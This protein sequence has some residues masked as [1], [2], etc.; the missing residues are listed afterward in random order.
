[1]AGEV[2]VDGLA[3]HDPGRA[4][5][6]ADVVGRRPHLVDGSPNRFAGV[7]RLEAPEL[8]GM[9]L[10]GLGE[11]QEHE[12]SVLGRRVL[13]G[14]EGLGGRPDR[15]IDVL[16]TAGR[17]AADDLA[18]RGVEDVEELATRG[19]DEFAPDEL[20]MGRDLLLELG[21]RFILQSSWAGPARLCR[22]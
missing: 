17:D 11:L 5:E 3:L 21:H 15:A 10:D 18:R 16:R 2:L 13:P 22:P 20:P 8:L 1:M 14:L 12:A 9:G 6:E 4:G 7:R 19:L